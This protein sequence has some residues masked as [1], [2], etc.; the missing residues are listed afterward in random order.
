MGK[1]FAGLILAVI[2]LFVMEWFG[3]IDIPYVELPDLTAGKEHMMKQTVE[4][5]DNT[6]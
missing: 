3:I 2:A 1:Y 6:G 5:I 4:N